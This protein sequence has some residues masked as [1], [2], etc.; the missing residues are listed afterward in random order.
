MDPVNWWFI[1]AFPAFLS[2]FLKS[3]VLSIVNFSQSQ[4]LQTFLHWAIDLCIQVMKLLANDRSILHH[5]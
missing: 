3:I 4:M 1:T 5:W 2:D